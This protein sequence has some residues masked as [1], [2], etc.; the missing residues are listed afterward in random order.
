M[1]G[2]PAGAPDTLPPFS[3]LRLSRKRIIPY[4]QVSLVPPIHREIKPKRKDGDVFMDCDDAL[5][6]GM[7]AGR[8][9]AVSFPVQFPMPLSSAA[10][11]RRHDA[12]H[13]LSQARMRCAQVSKRRADHESDVSAISS[14]LSSITGAALT[15]AQQTDAALFGTPS[16]VPANETP[17]Q[18]SDATLLDVNSGSSSLASELQAGMPPDLATASALVA[19]LAI[20]I[21]QQGSTAASIYSLLSADN[22][23]KLTQV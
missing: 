9:Q 14:D 10:P 13:H 23:L 19:N 1:S 11:S 20:Q 21:G 2:A 22:T 17:E 18:Q 15:P 6:E 3:A 5:A 12:D 8:T 7:P 16:P 4:P